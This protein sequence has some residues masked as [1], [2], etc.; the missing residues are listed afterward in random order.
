MET[1]TLWFMSLFVALG[2]LLVGLSI[3]L[4]QRWV[5]PNYFYGVRTAKTL[6]NERIW[7]EANAYAG[8]LLLRAGIV[9]VVAAIALYFVLRTNSIAYNI[10]CTVVLLSTALIHLVLS[11]RHLRS[12]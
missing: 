3:P 11:L 4:I 6:S 10:A 7:Y 12:L 1:T 5:K 9:L 8:R 2:I